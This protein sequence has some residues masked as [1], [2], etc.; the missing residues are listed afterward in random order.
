M[1]PDP[2]LP[3]ASPGSSTPGPLLARWPV[4][5]GQHDRP[6]GHQARREQLDEQPSA[7]PGPGLARRAAA[8]GAAVQ[9]SE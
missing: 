6:D 1:A 8:E 7:I 5:P 9:A 4:A 3:G 2:F